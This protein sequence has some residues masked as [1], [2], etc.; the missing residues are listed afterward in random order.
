MEWQQFRYKVEILLA[1]GADATIVSLQA[2]FWLGVE[3]ESDVDLFPEAVVT[4][5]YLYHYKL[6]IFVYIIIVY[7]S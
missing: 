6:N 1:H 4:S 5:I 2:R 7:K 3:V